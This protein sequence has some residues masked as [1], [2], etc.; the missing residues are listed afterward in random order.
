MAKVKCPVCEKQ[1][2]RDSM[3]TIPYKKRY[4]CE[5]CFCDNF[6]EDEVS[7]HFFYLDFQAVI[8][9]VPAQ[10]EWLQCN[11]LLDAGWSW[12]KIHDV[13][14]YTYKIEENRISEEHG[15]I[16]VLPYVEFRA[17]TFLK[18]KW[19][20]DDHN[21]NVPVEDEVEEVVYTS[22]NHIVKQPIRTKPKADIEAILNN[23]DLWED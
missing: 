17:K 12:R 7:K 19:D 22:A 10:L 4:Y 20:A 6:S 21:V 5:D 9:R 3:Q 16:G 13:F 14:M 15:T 23:D 8:G 18:L 1:I 2:E 11:K